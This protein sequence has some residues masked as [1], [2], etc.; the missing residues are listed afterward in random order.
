MACDVMHLCDSTDR[1]IAER[2]SHLSRAYQKITLERIYPHS[3]PGLFASLNSLRPITDLACKKLSKQAYDRIDVSSDQNNLSFLGCRR[4]L[5][6][7]SK[8]A[9]C[10]SV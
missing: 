5:I 3:I 9:F 1:I 2:A 10:G 4:A 6:R 8:Q 7:H